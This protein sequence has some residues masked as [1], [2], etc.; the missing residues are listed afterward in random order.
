MRELLLGRAVRG[1]DVVVKR[2]QNQVL[3][4]ADASQRRHLR[5][6]ANDQSDEEDKRP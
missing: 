5:N 3:F 4:L 2:E 1:A 6:D